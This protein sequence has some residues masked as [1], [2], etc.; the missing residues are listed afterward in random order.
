MVDLIIVFFALHISIVDIKSHLIRNSELLFYAIPLSLHSHRLPL[1]HSALAITLAFGPCLIFKIGGG[2]LKLFSLL[3][4]TQGYLIITQS[5]FLHMYVAI[6]ILLVAT[7]LRHRKWSQSV[8]LAPAI[9]APFL[10]AYLD[11]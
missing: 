4:M 10:L 7:Y 6:L 3:T 5:F 9:L 8:P 2:D 1:S 11:I